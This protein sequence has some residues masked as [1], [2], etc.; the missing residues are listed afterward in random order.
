MSEVTLATIDVMLGQ[1]EADRKTPY[2]SDKAD[3]LDGA[4]SWL[5]SLRD[6]IECRS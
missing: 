1:L 5:L 4:Q 6:H 3:W 2:W